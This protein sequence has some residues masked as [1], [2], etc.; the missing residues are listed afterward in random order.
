MTP[1]RPFFD[2]SSAT[3]NPQASVAIPRGA[4]RPFRSRRYTIHLT[5]RGFR[6]VQPSWN[7]SPSGPCGGKCGFWRRGL[8][9][10]GPPPAAVGFTPYGPPPTA[11]FKIHLLSVLSALRLVRFSPWGTTPSAASANDRIGGAQAKGAPDGGRGVHTSRAA[12]PAG[13]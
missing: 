13:L 2:H 10:R 1:K 9:R 8:R 5:P 7:R 3:P 6:Q 12:T 4:C 11:C